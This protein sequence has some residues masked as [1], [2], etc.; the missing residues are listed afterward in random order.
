M[1][2]ERNSLRN[3]VIITLMVF[4]LGACASVS[5]STDTSVETDSRDIQGNR[6]A[7]DALQDIQETENYNYFE[8]G[9]LRITK[10]RNGV[11]GIDEWTTE[12]P[13]DGPTNNCSSMY[14]VLDEESDQAILVDGGNGGTFVDSND[15]MK[16]ILDTL[17]KGMDFNVYLTHR[18][19]DH[20]GLLTKSTV[21][22]TDIPIYIHE[23]DLI[24]IKNSDGSAYQI[25]TF[26]EGDIIG[27]ENFRF[28]VVNI[29][30]HS[31]G[32]CALID[33]E[34]EFIFSGDAIGSG[35]VWLFGSDDLIT[36]DKG[37]NNLYNAIKDMKNPI[38]YSGHRW[39]QFIADANTKGLAIGEI[40]KDYVEQILTL[41]KEI[42][43]GTSRINN[44]YPASPNPAIYSATNGIDTG[45][46]ATQEAIDLYKGL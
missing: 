38:M 5:D 46:V 4:C 35:S 36:Y 8:Q 19:G 6:I 40:G 1:R 31:P 17:V 29:P 10:L 22:G 33:Y 34:H 27:T 41:L 39:Q 21:I 18:H 7:V 14:L 16:I 43:N 30:G 12:H 26:K 13:A 9:D 15:D 11:Y 37:V 20:T 28:N 24:E 45:I 23:N 32:S 25:I 3:F 2:K 42:K 44:E